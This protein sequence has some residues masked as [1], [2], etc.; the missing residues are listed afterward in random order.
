MFRKE[1]LIAKASKNEVYGEI[2]LASPI[3]HTLISVFAVVCTLVTAA[4]LFGGYYTKRVTAHGELIPES[5]VTQVYAI[6]SGLIKSRSVSEGQKVKAGDTLFVLSS[7][8]KSQKKQAIQETINAAL[9]DKRSSLASA[10]KTTE[11]IHALEM[12]A[13]RNNAS[14]LTRERDN[15]DQQI[16]LA[17][18]KMALSEGSVK[19]YK[20]LMEQGYIAPEQLDQKQE[21]LLEQKIRLKD[22]ERSR[23]DVDYKYATV[24]QN[25]SSTPLTQSNI[26]EELTRSLQVVD[27][28]MVENEAKYET[29]ISAPGDG[30]VTAIRGNV[31][32]TAK[33]D[34]ALAAIVPGDSRFQAHLYVSS[35]AVGFI[36]K[37]A[38]VGVRYQS[39][40]YQKFGQAKG[41]VLEISEAPLLPVEIPPIANPESSKEPMY[42]VTVELERQYVRAYG[43]VIPLRAG[44]L[45]DAD[46]MLEKRKLYEWIVEP[47][48]SITGKI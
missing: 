7:D 31:G 9:Q 29:V 15:L 45:L 30:I 8:R 21:E 19:R 23:A 40:P 27:Q 39:F 5:G 48:Y 32:Q 1:A 16:S 4:F 44:M 42:R 2:I 11:H 43:D 13:L 22:L 25:I 20:G 41:T 12:E 10:I 34:E 37:G 47:I 24:V 33:V 28:E 36:R 17:V 6:Q 38:V 46:V 18:K 3:N 26:R 14:T 35:R